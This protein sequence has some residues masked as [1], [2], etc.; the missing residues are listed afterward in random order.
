M[1]LARGSAKRGGG[2][3]RVDFDEVAA[4][5]PDRDREIV[6]IDDALQQ[7]AELDPRKAKVI[8]LRFFGGLSVEET[9]EALHLFPQSVMRD[10]KLAKAW[11][12]RELSKGAAAAPD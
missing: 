10:W 1:R 11:L 12:Y 6:A 3:Q 8:E 7:L 4:V 9:A 2:A 5:S